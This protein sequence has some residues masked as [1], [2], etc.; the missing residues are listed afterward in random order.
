MS[1]FKK[2]Y[3]E[4]YDYLYQNKDYERECDF[5]EAAFK[6]YGC[7]V[8]TIL[9]LGCGTGGHALILSQRGF[10]VVGVDKSE[11]ML[12]IA[13]CKA[14]KDNLSAEFIQG[15]ITNIDLGRKFD[16]VVSMFA[17][18]GYQT[19]NSALSGA[20][21]VAESHMASDGFFLFDCWNGT[22]VLNERP[23]TRVKE[24]ELNDN[25]K[26]VRFT[27]PVIDTLSHIVET[28]FKVWRIN[29]D[30]LVSETQ[31]SHFMRYL[32]P[33]EIR[34]YLEVAGFRNVEF[35]PFPELEKP[36]TADDWNMAVIARR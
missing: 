18:I 4:F 14:R 5:I 35:S 21:R 29:G 31:E 24:V 11:E 25:E 6:K 10:N 16:A 19:T 26:I 8:K 33:Q 7:R 32:F 20:C 28:R 23:G 15:D 34:Y 17:V 1:V 22:A 3:A 12:N 30:R 13:I 36:L 2:Q 27:D 9:D